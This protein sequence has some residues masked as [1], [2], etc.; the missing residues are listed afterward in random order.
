MAARA[1]RMNE[2][3]DRRGDRTVEAFRGPGIARLVP[4]VAI[5]RNGDAV[6]LGTPLLHVNAEL[7]PGF[8]E[9]EGGMAEHAGSSQF[10][11]GFQGVFMAMAGGLAAGSTIIGRGER[12]AVEIEHRRQDRDAGLTAEQLHRQLGRAQ[13]DPELERLRRTEPEIDIVPGDGCVA[14]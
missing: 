12:A 10:L 4:A 1:Q 6:T 3:G 7:G 9:Q 11:Q 14:A 5:D 13:T 2:T 8:V